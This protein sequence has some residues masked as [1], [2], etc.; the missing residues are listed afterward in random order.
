MKNLFKG[1]VYDFLINQSVNNRMGW[2]GNAGMIDGYSDKDLENSK[3]AVEYLTNLLKDIN[4]KKI[5]ET[6]TNYGTFS[7]I[8]YE[9][10]N[11]FKLY[12]CDFLGGYPDSSENCINFINSNYG[13]ENVKFHHMDS[14]KFLTQLK[15]SGE[16]FDLAWLDSQHEYT[17]LLQELTIAGEMEIPYIMI[18]D[19]W[20]VQNLQLAIF[21]FLKQNQ[22]YRFHSF[23]NIRESIGSIVL[24]QKI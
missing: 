21:E 6:G 22:N 9:I 5:I 3:N 15:D 10:L 2:K 20:F 13:K 7:Y 24:L 12:T 14:I 19:F 8:L 11:D 4:P 18:D 17:F 16:K 1:P 23:S